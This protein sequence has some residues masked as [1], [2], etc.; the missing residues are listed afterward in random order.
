[1]RAM[2]RDE[3]ADWIARKDD[4]CAFQDIARAVRC[5]DMTEARALAARYRGWLSSYEIESFEKF[6]LL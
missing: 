6:G 1:M 3:I 5:G 2:T 4:C